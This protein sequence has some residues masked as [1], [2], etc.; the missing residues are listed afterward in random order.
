VRVSPGTAALGVVGLVGGVLA[1]GTL[2]EATLSTHQPVP[3][4][5]QVELVVSA[6]TRGGE[7]G[8]SLAEMVESQIVS[9]RLEVTSDMVGDV[10]PVGDGRTFRAVLSPAMDETNRRQFRG[11]LEDWHTDHLRMDVV[12]LDEPD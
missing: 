9:C 12:S 6:E 8:Q 11:C 2:R 5:S 4:G 10:E 3:P 7:P 1:V